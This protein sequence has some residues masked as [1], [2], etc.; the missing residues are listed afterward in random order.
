MLFNRYFDADFASVIG[1]SKTNA[2][3]TIFAKYLMGKTDNFQYSTIVEL[4]RRIAVISAIKIITFTGSS[5]FTLR[6]NC[7]N[8]Y[9]KHKNIKGDIL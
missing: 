9:I 3:V 5:Y 8:L 7:R 2:L 1:L 4:V 6:S